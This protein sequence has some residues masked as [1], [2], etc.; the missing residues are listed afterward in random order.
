[1]KKISVIGTLLVLLYLAGTAFCWYYARTCSG[2]YCGYVIVIPVL[3][4]I[5]LVERFLDH[6]LAY[7][8]YGLIIL[9]NITLA[10]LIGHGTGWCFKKLFIKPAPKIQKVRT[11]T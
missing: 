6:D 7:F 8:A 4:W 2:Q 11:R 9:F 10:Y 1:M 3:P 5:V